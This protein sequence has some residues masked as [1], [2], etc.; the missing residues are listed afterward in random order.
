MEGS[1]GQHDEEVPPKVDDEECE[2][3]LSAYTPPPN[4]GRRAATKFEEFL[5]N[6]EWF[7][8]PHTVWRRVKR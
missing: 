5:W 2:E 7:A 6:A 3:T 1:V 8:P 4:S